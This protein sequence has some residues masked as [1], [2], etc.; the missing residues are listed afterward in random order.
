M[1]VADLHGFIDYRTR[2][3]EW[4]EKHPVNNKAEKVNIDALM[5]KGGGNL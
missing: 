4:Y 3:A 5:K 2:K 1:S